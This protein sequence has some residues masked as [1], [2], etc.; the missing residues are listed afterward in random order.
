VKTTDGPGDACSIALLNDK[1]GA[2]MV[3]PNSDI[4]SQAL[5]V[6]RQVETLTLGSAKFK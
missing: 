2:G 5:E 3:A 4:A 6:P 1:A